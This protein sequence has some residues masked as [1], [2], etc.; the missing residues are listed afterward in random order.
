MNK[1]RL[2][3]VIG[4]IILVGLMAIG[5]YVF[6]NRFHYGLFC[7]F[8]EAFGLD[9]PGCGVSRMFFSIM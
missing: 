9:C 3:I 1:K 2:L 5:Y 6:Y 8:H 4:S 7:P